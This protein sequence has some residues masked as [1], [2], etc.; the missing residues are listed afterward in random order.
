MT[1]KD[2]P[3]DCQLI[4]FR[5]ECNPS[6]PGLGH[7]PVQAPAPTQV[8]A[9]VDPSQVPAGTDAPAQHAPIDHVL[10]PKDW[11]PPSWNLHTPSVH[12]V[13][14]MGEGAGAVGL[15]AF[16]A[17]LGLVRH[18][19][20]TGLEP[21]DLGIQAAGAAVMPVGAIVIDD[22]W[23]APLHLLADAA[24]AA[25][26]GGGYLFGAMAAASITAIPL[27]WTAAALWW[28]RRRQQELDGRADDPKKSVR[29]QR[30]HEAAK[31]RAGRKAAKTWVP[32]TTGWPVPTHVVLGVCSKRTCATPETMW[33]ALFSRHDNKLAIPLSAL[34]E[35]LFVL[36]GTGSGKTT[37]L[38][39]LAVAMFLADW[40]RYLAGGPRPLLVFLDCGGDIKTARRFVEIMARLGI[41]PDRIGLWPDNTDLDLWA[42]PAEETTETLQKMACPVPPTDSAQEYF[43]KGRRRVIRLAMGTCDHIGPAV[44]APTSRRELFARL[45]STDALK[46]LYPMDKAIGEEIDGFSKAKPPMVASV[47]GIL[48]DVWDTLGSSLDTG[49]PL[50]AYDALFLRVPGTTM[51]DAA[52]SQAAALLEMVLKFAA[53]SDHGRRLRMIVDE[54]SAANDNG[55]DIGIVEILERA[56]KYDLSIVLSAQNEEGIGPDADTRKRI[57]KGASGG[58]ILMRGRGFGEACEVFGTAPKAEATRH[59]MGGGHGDEGS[60][61]VS[62]KFLVSPEACDEMEKGDAVYVNRRVAV[63]GH[64]TELDLA[65]LPR[66][67]QTPDTVLTPVEPRARLRQVPKPLAD[68]YDEDG[69]DDVPNLGDAAS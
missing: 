31:A 7:A 3:P 42:G 14:E 41:Q 68:F 39:R 15:M 34:D 38:L 5:A 10:P 29:M 2:T 52:R 6:S 18:A 16:A 67:E 44:P 19:R 8:P 23:T 30:R 1:W 37:M 55:A 36:G 12:Q 53:R 62:D 35:H 33:S 64:V 11:N 20:N 9:A 21:R 4:D 25:Q 59:T 45:A 66:I 24:H 60:V 63:W 56:R 40:A 58:A 27:G 13:M 17:A 28:S 57:M 22:S 49:K 54:T 47:G 61:G 50:T 48:R 51:K 43:F 69:D 26:L 32:Y 46:R 65:D